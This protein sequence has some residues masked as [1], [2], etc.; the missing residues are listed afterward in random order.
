MCTWHRLH[1]V[2]NLVYFCPIWDRSW[3][4]M[5]YRWYWV[6]V[7]W[8]VVLGLWNCIPLTKIINGP[9]DC[10]FPFSL[11]LNMTSKLLPLVAWKRR[12]VR[13]AAHTCGPA[14]GHG[15]TF[16]QV[17]VSWNIVKEPV[18]HLTKTKWHELALAVMCIT[19]YIFFN[20]Q[21]WSYSKAVITT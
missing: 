1:P 18:K 2:V 14:H 12:E 17:Y 8:A 7:L 3:K 11:W 19:T 10:S 15:A 20:D 13:G 4:S 16:G 6:F 9:C 5:K 21:K